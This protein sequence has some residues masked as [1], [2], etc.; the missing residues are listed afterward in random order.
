M[1]K[2]RIYM[3][4]LLLPAIVFAQQPLYRNKNLPPKARAADLVKRMTVDEKMMQT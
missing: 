1:K 3:L 4:L 2:Y